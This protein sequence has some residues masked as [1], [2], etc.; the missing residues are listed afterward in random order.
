MFLQRWYQS[1]MLLFKLCS[2]LI[3]S[4]FLQQM[5]PCMKE[6]AHLSVYLIYFYSMTS[7]VPGAGY[8]GILKRS[9]WSSAGSTNIFCKGPDS[10]Y[11]RL[12][13]PRGKSR[14]IYRQMYNH[15]KC[16]QYCTIQ[17]QALGQIWLQAS[18]LI[19]ALVRQALIKCTYK[20]MTKVHL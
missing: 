15:S 6:S 8:I 14:I 20:Y 2:L 18:L 12:C 16:K 9:V 17:K 10:K 4:T 7:T 5:M 13:E 3:Q 1:A 19:P 11:V